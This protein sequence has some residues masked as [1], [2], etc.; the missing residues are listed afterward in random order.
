[1]YISVFRNTRSWLSANSAKISKQTVSWYMHPPDANMYQMAFQRTD[2]PSCL[3]W[4]SRES[5]R[6]VPLRNMWKN[7]CV[8]NAKKLTRKAKTQK[9]HVIVRN[10]KKSNPKYLAG[11][12]CNTHNTKDP[13]LWCN[14]CGVSICI[15]C[16]TEQH[17]GH[18]FSRITTIIL[19]EKRDAILEE[20]NTVRVNVV[21][22]WEEQT[23]P[24]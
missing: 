16:S 24:S 2:G 1:M 9:R 3:R 20:I 12:L 17:I 21:G 15:P 7:A 5:W 13:E 18:N 19:S 6:Q 23:D 11:L 22:Q 10:A 14:T 4:M 8:P